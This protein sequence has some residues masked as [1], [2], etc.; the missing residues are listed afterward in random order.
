[1]MI[2]N[3]YTTSSFRPPSRNLVTCSRFQDSDT[4]ARCLHRNDEVEIGGNDETGNWPV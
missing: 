1:M 3:D 4:S 2:S